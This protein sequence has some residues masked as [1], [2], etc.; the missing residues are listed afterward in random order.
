MSPVDKKNPVIKAHNWV[1]RESYVHGR[2]GTGSSMTS[3]LLAWRLMGPLVMLGGVKML[4]CLVL[5]L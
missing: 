3:A 4:L 5:L 1:D 2:A